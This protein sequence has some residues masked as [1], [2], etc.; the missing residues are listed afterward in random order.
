VNSKVE[1]ILVAATVGLAISAP[2]ATQE[3]Q[4]EKACT[5]P[6]YSQFDFWSGIYTRDRK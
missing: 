4:P 6:K 5:D 2:L 3:T 1:E